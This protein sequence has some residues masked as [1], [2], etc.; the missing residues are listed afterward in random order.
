MEEQTE[1]MTD[2]LV[3]ELRAI[4]SGLWAELVEVDGEYEVMGQLHTT[5]PTWDGIFIQCEPDIESWT[6]EEAIDDYERDQYETTRWS[7]RIGY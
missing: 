6:V 4:S 7:T 2:D 1:T 5:R 3:D